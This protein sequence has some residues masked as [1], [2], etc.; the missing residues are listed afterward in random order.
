MFFLSSG[1]SNWIMVGLTKLLTL[2]AILQV[3]KKLPDIINGIFGTNIK[4]RGGI[5]GRLSEM[6][7]V[8]QLAANAWTALGKTGKNLAKLGLT[9]PAAGGF[10]AANALY[11]KKT[12]K[13]LKD[14]PAFQTGKG[15]LY[16]ARQSV[17]TGSWMSGYQEYEKESTPPTHTRAQLLGAE[18]RINDR[19]SAAGLTSKQG[20]WTNEERDASG[21]PI[22]GADGKQRFKTTAKIKDEI[23]QTLGMVDQTFGDSKLGKQLAASMHAG[24]DAQIKYNSLMAVQNS[25]EKVAGYANNVYS[26]LNSN[27]SLYKASEINQ[28]REIASRLQSGNRLVTEDDAKFLVKYMDSE[29]ATQFTTAT[30]KYD[31]ALQTAVR[32]TEYKP[33]D[34]YA[35]GSLGGAVNNAKAAVDDIDREQQNIIAQMSDIDKVAYQTYNNPLKQMTGSLAVANQFN[36]AAPTDQVVDEAGNQIQGW[37]NSNALVEGPNAEVGTGTRDASTASS[38]YSQPAVQILG[39]DGNPIVRES[40]PTP[41]PQSVQEH[42]AADVVPADDLETEREIVNRVEELRQ[43][44]TSRGLN[45]EQR[46]EMNDLVSDLRR[47]QSNRNRRDE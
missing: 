43:I 28:A 38:S 35:V 26:M 45:D 39:S 46:E 34:L 17:K 1:S 33:L 22:Y 21:K 7:G 11:Y 32:D 20:T 31:D 30:K 47:R 25:G 41:A 23:G 3:V 24:A 4:T 18:Q 44:R 6:A 5:K 14:L 27:A 37:A 9:L 16:G 29:T 12:G 8:G 10:A 2:I 40:T 42:Q 19:L 13:Q 36:T 15:L